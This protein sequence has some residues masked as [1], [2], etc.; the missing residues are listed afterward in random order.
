MTKEKL[1]WMDSNPEEFFGIIRRIYNNMYGGGFISLV[2]HTTIPDNIEEAKNMIKKEPFD[3]YI[4]N[5]EFEKVIQYANSHNKMGPVSLGINSFK[6]ALKEKSRIIIISSN[7]KTLE[8]A[9]DLDLPFYY[10]L[11]GQET[12][13]ET[14]YRIKKDTSNRQEYTEYGQVPIHDFVDKWECGG[15]QEF[16]EKYLAK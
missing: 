13:K 4:L 16:I 11:G 14:L 12:V 8:R 10:K 5:H 15:V 9:Y 7:D 6:D 1:F 3:M 2:G